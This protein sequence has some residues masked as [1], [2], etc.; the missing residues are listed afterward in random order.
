MLIHWIPPSDDEF[1]Q[2]KCGRPRWEYGPRETDDVDRK[3]VTCRTCLKD[4]KGK[5]MIVIDSNGDA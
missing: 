2:A 1:S 3:E 5:K 4:P